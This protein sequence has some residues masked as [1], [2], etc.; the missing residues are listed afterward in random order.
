VGQTQRHDQEEHDAIPENGQ[1]DRR[2]LKQ[3]RDQPTGSLCARRQGAGD[4]TAVR[5]FMA[6]QRNTI[7]LARRYSGA[8]DPDEPSAEA[9]S[10]LVAELETMLDKFEQQLDL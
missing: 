10:P 7:S 2:D 3:D 8:A 6:E 9:R 4:W 1:G 5:G